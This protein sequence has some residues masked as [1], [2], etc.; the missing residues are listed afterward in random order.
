MEITVQ[1]NYG[2][3]D[4]VIFSLEYLNKKGV[5]GEGNIEKIIVWL[6]VVVGAETRVVVL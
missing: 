5:V 4:G 1:K 3:R 6:S 2:M